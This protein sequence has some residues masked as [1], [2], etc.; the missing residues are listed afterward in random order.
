MLSA[1]SS[2]TLSLILIILVCIKTYF[3]VIFELD[4]LTFFNSFEHKQNKWVFGV[5]YDV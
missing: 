4:G 5:E 3:Y 1:L 2:Q